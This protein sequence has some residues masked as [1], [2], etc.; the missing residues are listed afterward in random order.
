MNEMEQSGW[1]QKARAVAIMQ[2][3]LKVT[4]MQGQGSLVGY[5]VASETMIPL[6]RATGP[7]NKVPWRPHLGVSVTIACAPMKIMHM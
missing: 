3:G 7:I 1:M 4:C 2:P 5:F 6:L